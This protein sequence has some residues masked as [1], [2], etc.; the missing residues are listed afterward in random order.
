M[1]EMRCGGEGR[2]RGVLLSLSA[3]QSGDVD[4]SLLVANVNVSQPL[5]TS[6]YSLCTEAVDSHDLARK[7]GAC[8]A[9]EGNE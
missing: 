1:L 7:A 6:C 8:I 3:G 4:G 5:W 2:R 9:E